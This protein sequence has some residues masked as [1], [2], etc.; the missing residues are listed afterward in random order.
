MTEASAGTVPAAA[1][2]RGNL[3]LLAAQFRYATRSFWRTPVAAFF[4]VVFPLLLL[5]LLSALVGNETVDSRQGIRLAQFL[6]PAMAVF[7][8][9]TASF[10][11]LAISLSL[12]RE[13]GILKRLRGTPLPPWVFMTAQIASRVWIGLLSVLLMV[14]V[15]VLLYDVRIVGRTL[16]A[17]LVTLA[18]GIGCF[19]ALGLALVSLVRSAQA[20]QGLAST[21]IVLLGF[22]SDLFITGR[23]LPRWLEVTGWVFPLKHFANAMGDAFNPYHTGSGFAPGHLAVMA[24][25]GLAGVL[26]ALRRFSWDPYGPRAGRGAAAPAGAGGGAAEAAAE[27]WL[28]ARPAGP[29]RRPPAWRLLRGQVRYA[30]RVIARD[31]ASVFFSVLLP[32]LLAVLFPLVFGQ[33]ELVPGRDVELPQFLAPVLAV[34][35]LAVA[36]YVNLPEGVARA[37]DLGILKRLRGTPLPAWSYLAG[38]I[39]SALWVGLLAVVLTVGVSVLLYDVQVPGR[40][41][42]AVLVTLVVGTVCFAA[43][44]LAVAALV[45]DAQTFAVVALATLLSLSFISDIFLV[46]AQM[47]RWVEV[48]GWLFPLKHL[49]NAMADAFDPGVGGSG[50]AWG[51]LAVVAAWGVAGMLVAAARLR[52]DPRGER[53]APG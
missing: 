43:V 23:E 38:R 10:T 42:P 44:G 31:R 52:L 40:T 33:H 6:T 53:Q 1:G 51:H 5:L 8:A 2:R 4:T 17:V 19:A 24:A 49:A 26:V 30:N 12:A 32:A 36:A 18:V 13:Q 27:A 46:G 39:G 3:A 21:V 29:A 50:F 22:V 20:V 47:P 15:G 35:G 25:W 41:L 37:R 34:Y 45:P 7:G 28:D 14:A 9:V 16:P 11:S 48:L